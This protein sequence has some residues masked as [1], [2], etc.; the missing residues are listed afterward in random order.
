[1]IQDFKRIAVR[2]F[3]KGL[4]DQAL[5]TRFIGQQNDELSSLISIV[6]EAEEI[7]EEPHGN[8]NVV[9]STTPCSF[10]QINGHT[11]NRFCVPRRQVNMGNRSQQYSYR[12]TGNGGDNGTIRDNRP[13]NQIRS[14]ARSWC[15]SNAINRGTG[16]GMQSN[17]GPGQA[18]QRSDSEA[19]EPTM[20]THK[21]V[22]HKCDANKMSVMHKA[23]ET[24]VERK[25]NNNIKNRIEMSSKTYAD[26]A[27]A[28]EKITNEVSREK[29][30]STKKIEQNIKN[31]QKGIVKEEAMNVF[32]GESIPESKKLKG[33]S[34]TLGVVKID[35]GENKQQP[36]MFQVVARGSTIKG[37][38]ILGRDN[39]WGKS[40]LD[41]IRG[42]LKIFNDNQW[43]KTFTLH[44]AHECEAGHQ[45][46]A[47]LSKRAATTVPVDPVFKE[48]RAMVHRKEISPHV[49]GGYFSQCGKE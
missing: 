6:E 46:M 29:P 3:I 38:G 39:I 22:A 36:W 19:E 12:P 23:P 14:T 16:P 33:V 15:A 48:N 49:Y 44:A 24:G 2:S 13:R 4:R 1:M 11:G 42:T 18:N 17:L 47:C 32:P 27:V 35:V 26:I 20:I 7:L 5:K 10:C 40:K 25:H 43:V 34:T 31:K 21:V 30:S 8:V 41:S 9:S 45:R 37:D 28:N